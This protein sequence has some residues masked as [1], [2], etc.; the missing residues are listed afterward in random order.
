MTTPREF[1]EDAT[2]A[3]CGILHV[4]P[5]DNGEQVADVIEQ[6]VKK[7]TLERE[8]VA[9]KQIEE[10]RVAA[11]DHVVHLLS[12]SPAVLYSFEATGDYAPTFVSNNLK[13]LFGYEPREYMEDPE[14]WRRRVHPD[15]LSRVESAFA[16]VLEEGRQETEYR[17]RRKDGAYSWVS[18]GQHVIRDENGE[19][20][21]ITYHVQPILIVTLDRV[22]SDEVHRLRAGIRNDNTKRI[23]RGRHAR[24]LWNPARF[25]ER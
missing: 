2:R 12:S 16:R 25:S 24:S 23:R 5:N 6:A 21:E 11:Q 22:P 14:F 19:P 13:L 8:A 15:D 1:A 9:Q 20:V 10:V 17:F 4:S 18:D 7:A 3:V